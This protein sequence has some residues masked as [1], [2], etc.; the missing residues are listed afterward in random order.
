MRQDPQEKEILKMKKV[1][2]LNT[3]ISTYPLI[4]IRELN[5]DSIST[6]TP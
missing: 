5:L 6:F 4:S 3:V 2:V 1:K